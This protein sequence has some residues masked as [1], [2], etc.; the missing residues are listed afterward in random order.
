MKNRVLR[1]IRGGSYSNVTG[2]LRTT[3]SFGSEPEVRAGYD[4]FRIVIRRRKP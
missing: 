4:G 3:V 1:V 2:S